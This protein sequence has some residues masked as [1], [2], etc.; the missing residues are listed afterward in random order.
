MRQQIMMQKSNTFSIRSE[1]VRDGRHNRLDDFAS[2]ETEND[3]L[4]KQ[5]AEVER[6]F[7]LSNQ[8]FFNV[9][10]QKFLTESEYDFYKSEAQR[11]LH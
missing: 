5:I 10:Q 3:Q 6:T 8:E 7:S 1:P 4:T 11:E 9:S 2:I